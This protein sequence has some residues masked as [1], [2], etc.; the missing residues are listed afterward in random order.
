MRVLP[1]RIVLCGCWWFDPSEVRDRRR[2]LL[3]SSLLDASA[4]AEFTQYSSCLID[5]ALEQFLDCSDALGVQALLRF[6][7]PE[8]HERVNELLL[9]FWRHHCQVYNPECM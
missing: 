2:W 9:L 5:G 8:V 6:H 1:S 3:T 7:R 4:H